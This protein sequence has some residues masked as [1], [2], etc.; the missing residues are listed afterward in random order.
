MYY[1]VHMHCRVHMHYMCTVGYICTEEYMCTVGYI[2]H[3]FLVS[4]DL[5]CSNINLNNVQVSDM[6]FEIVILK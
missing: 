5:L 6:N 4:I 1:R 3:C 2:M